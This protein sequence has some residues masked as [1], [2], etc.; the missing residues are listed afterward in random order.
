MRL[1]WRAKSVI[2]GAATVGAVALALA[3]RHFAEGLTLN[4]D[5]IAV[6]SLFGALW[7]TSWL[8]PLVIY[9][10][11]QSEACHLDE[12]FLVVMLLLVPG[13]AIVVTVAAATVMAQAIRR[14]P[15]VKAVFNTGQVVCSVWAGSAVYGLIAHG[16]GGAITGTH[17]L[18]AITG[19]A[20]LFVVNSLSV[21][22]VLVATGETWRS[23][24][25]ARCSPGTSRPATTGAGCGACSR[26]RSTSPG[27]WGRRR[28]PM[29]SCARR[30][31][32]CAV[33]R[34]AWPAG[35]RRPASC[36]PGSTSPT[37]PS[38]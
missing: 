14:R 1:P 2:V 29:P 24:C 31:S 12:G 9:R 25:C 27:P 19:A 20:V 32:S 8:W 18:G 22:L 37:T 4:G 5:Q 10:G 17:I 7:V 28:R 35:A 6:V 21:A 11:E 16:S 15:F 33:A 13:P 36:R 34:C 26:R 23:S 30:A 3:V 38:Y